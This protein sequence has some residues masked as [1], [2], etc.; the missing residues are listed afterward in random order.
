MGAQKNPL[1]EKFHFSTHNINKEID[2][3][4]RAEPASIEKSRG[5][6]F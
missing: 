5:P 4:N 6:R 1:I 2:L 3:S